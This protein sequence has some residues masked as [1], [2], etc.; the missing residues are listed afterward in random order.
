MCT[1]G[2]LAMSGAVLIGVFD[3]FTS[4]TLGDVVNLAVVILGNPV[5]SHDMDILLKQSPL[6]PC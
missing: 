6:E 1:H 4:F 3:G 2:G 5:R